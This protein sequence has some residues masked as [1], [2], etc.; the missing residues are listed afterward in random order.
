MTEEPVMGIFAWKVPGV[1]YLV[2]ADTDYV[3]RYNATTGNFESPLGAVLGGVFTGT[4]ADFFHFCPFETFMVINNGVDKPQKYTPATPAIADMGTEFDGAGAGDK[5]EAAKFCFR[6]S[7]R[8]VYIGLQEGA[9]WYLNRA[10]WTP[11]NDVE[12]ASATADAADYFVDAPTN[13]EL[14]AAEMIGGEIVCLFGTTVWKLRYTG[15]TPYDAFVWEQLPAVEGTASP[16]GHVSLG[17]ALLYR[18]HEGINLTDAHGVQAADLEIPD[19]VLTWNLDK[20]QYSYG[21]YVPSEHEALLTY[22][23]SDDDYAER[24]LVAHLDRGRKFLGWSQYDLPFHCLG[25]YRRG[26]VQ[27][28]D[29]AV[30]GLTVDEIMW[31]P[32]SLAKSVEFPIVLAGD[33]DGN[34]YEYADG[35]TDDGTAVTAT[36]R[37]IRISP[38][39][40]RRCHLGW[41]DIIADAITDGEIT[42]TAYADYQT[43]AH[44]NVT[45]DLTATGESA[46]V[47]RRVR[48]NRI[49]HFH[50]IQLVVTSSGPFALDAVTPWCQP[51]GRMRQIA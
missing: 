40:G 49:A 30:A 45:V 43:T 23:D 10:R 7:G 37:T 51:A 14:Y 22:A 42:V 28:W 46:K 36:M 15:G 24:A 27:T 9:K 6:H 44:T 35:Y 13:D 20:E 21:I 26:A 3:W 34:I 48:I 11:V 29:D 4:D 19:E 50:T 25:R 39:P 8:L 31:S 17:D 18:G 33:R 12:Y 5:I 1:E 16:M 2:A 38:Y 41:V 32:D 47:N